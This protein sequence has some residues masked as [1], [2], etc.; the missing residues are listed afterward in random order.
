MNQG[1]AVSVMLPV[2]AVLTLKT[3]HF[4]ETA[5]NLTPATQLHGT[6]PLW[7]ART[8]VNLYGT[9]FD[10]MKDTSASKAAV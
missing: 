2:V 8:H 4:T 7:T 9:P 5:T 10:V 6:Y 1:L 3:R